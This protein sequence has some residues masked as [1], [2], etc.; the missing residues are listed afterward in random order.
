MTATEREE[1]WHKRLQAADETFEATC[2]EL[3]LVK[4]QLAALRQHDAECPSCGFLFTINLEE[5]KP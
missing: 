5:R 2:A 4:R 3:R 1:A